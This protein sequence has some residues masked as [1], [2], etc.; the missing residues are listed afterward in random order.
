MWS[1]I[2]ISLTLVT[3]SR[4][5][6]AP[7]VTGN[8]TEIQIKTADQLFAGMD[9]GHLDLI[10]CG[11]SECCLTER[12]ES[13][14]ESFQ[15]GQLDSFIGEDLQRCQNFGLPKNYINDILIAHRGIDNW[16]G[17]YL[18]VLLDSGVFYHCDIPD[19]LTS[20]GEINL[21]CS[22]KKNKDQ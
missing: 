15:R 10:V 13:G 7:A 17:E 3:L 14:D 11:Q 8:I 6:F 2:I 22:V 19:W 1:K 18:F 4:A 5:G 12:L 20:D 9:Y 21:D 16:R